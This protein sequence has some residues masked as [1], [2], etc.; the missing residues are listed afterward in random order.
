M[1]RLTYGDISREKTCQ[2]LGALLAFGNDGLDTEL[3]EQLRKKG[4]RCDRADWDS[5]SPKLDIRST[6]LLLIELV[7]I[8]YQ[9]T[10]L[11]NN[12]SKLKEALDHLEQ[13]V[14]Y[15]RLRRKTPGQPIV[16]GTLHLRFTDVERSLEELRAQWP[17]KGKGAS[18]ST[19]SSGPSASTQADSTASEKKNSQTEESQTKESTS[20][21]AGDSW[22]EL[23]DQAAATLKDAI[24]H[25]PLLRA[26]LK[27]L[28]INQKANIT[29]RDRQYLIQRVEKM[30][31]QDYLRNALGLTHQWPTLQ[32]D[33]TNAPS[34][35]SQYRNIFWENPQSIDSL[36]SHSVNISLI[37]RFNNIRP[38]R[39]LLILGAPGAGK[40]I[41]LL[42]LLHPLLAAAQ[43]KQQ[44]IPIVVNLSTYGLPPEGRNFTHW[45]ITQ[46]EQL[47]A[48][49]QARGRRFLEAQQLMLMLDGLDEVR[50]NLRTTC[51]RQ[52][53]EFLR[54]YP[55]TEC[56][57][58][59][60]IAEYET[61]R[62]SLQLEASLKLMPLQATQAIDYLNQLSN[63]SDLQSLIQA[64]KHNSDFQKFAETPLML[65]IMAVAY[66]KIAVT[67]LPKFS[68]IE[69]HRR[70]LYDAVL[71][72]LLMRQQPLNPRQ[73]PASQYGDEIYSPSEVRA[74]LIWLA[75]RMV[76][77]DQTTFFI[78]Q[79][80][81]SWLDTRRQR[82]GYRLNSHALV[83]LLLGTISA[84]HIA[85]LAGWH[86]TGE[87]MRFFPALLGIGAGGSLGASMLFLVLY[88]ALPRIVSG[89]ITA[90]AYVVFFGLVAHPFVNFTS[91][92]HYIA[93][94]S[95][96]AIDW[97]GMSLFWGLM[98]D[99]IVIVHRLSWSWSNALRFVSV[100][101][102]AYFGLYFPLRFFLLHQYQND[103]WTEVAYEPVLISGLTA[104]YGGFAWGN[105]P[106]PQ[107]IIRPN[108]GM[109]KALR[110]IA[111]LSTTM[112][113]VGVLAAQQYAHGNPYEYVMI[114]SS[115]GLMAAMLGGQRSGQVLIQHFCLRVILW[116]NRCAP[117]NYARFLDFSARRLLLQRAGGGYMFMHRSFMEHL[118]K[119]A[120]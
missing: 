89:F 38:V 79:L 115:I 107:T 72:R 14:G 64:I 27:V 58:C 96:L 4:L 51:I 74:W 48:L 11:I 28:G 13:T 82:Q 106:L 71:E 117:W 104:V 46:L 25:S 33:L 65:N 100:S 3:A 39:R 84:C 83:G 40:T 109:K 23:F 54:T 87:V 101:N 7:K 90:S 75:K 91:P 113:S 69:D 43:S 68:S 92:S 15:L 35:L 29:P 110:N 20:S 116:W 99:R 55:D 16:D 12:K 57:I 118:A 86:E 17:I 95:P 47:Y 41:A 6:R 30:W 102:L 59:S 88:R 76:E 112:G 103:H 22:E 31:L 45:L 24:P 44:P 63:T 1:G 5:S 9:S 26:V 52:I 81:P 18:Q 32:L 36:H 37:E 93:R 53:N 50:P 77:H 2:L 62:E 97:L 19:E 34:A 49:T 114:A 42:E 120:Q 10:A 61:S 60:R 108:Q 8:K 56:V 78:E 21:Q 73:L 67:E 94:L 66:Q 98:R 105:I 111:L 85:P 70:Y 80:R 119:K